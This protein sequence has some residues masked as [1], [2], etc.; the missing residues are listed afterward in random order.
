DEA[1]LIL[2]VVDASHP[3][4]EAQIEAVHQVF[5]DTNIADIQ[6]LIVFNKADASD[7]MVLA[8]LRRRYPSALVVSAATGEGFPELEAA[9]AEGLP[10]PSVH[11]DLLVPYTDGDVVNRLHS[12]DTEILA[13]TYEPEGTA[14]TVLV[15]P[16]DKDH[17]LSYV[18]RV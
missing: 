15:Y 4:P 2:H 8:R 10:R 6:E 7:P 12:D 11:M 5:L 17:Y 3:E 14:L 13:E 1:D 9:I 18:I 16:E